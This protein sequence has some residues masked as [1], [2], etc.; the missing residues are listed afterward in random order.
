[1]NNFFD[2][3]NFNYF[4]NLLRFT[5]MIQL[6]PK[7]N[8]TFKLNSSISVRLLLGV[9]CLPFLAFIYLLADFAA[10]LK[11]NSVSIFF[12]IQKRT[13]FLHQIKGRVSARESF[14]YYIACTHLINTKLQ[15]VSSSRRA[16][17]FLR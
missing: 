2:I 3:T 9:F 1:M 5:F 15:S 12:Y 6:V 7:K 17:L 11:V 4:E 10:S 13:F 16:T 8:K 14:F